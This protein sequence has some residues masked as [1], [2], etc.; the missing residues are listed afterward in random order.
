[1]SA[2]HSLLAQ[3]NALGSGMPLDTTLRASGFTLPA[4]PTT[5]TL[6]FQ[7]EPVSAD[8]T[9]NNAVVVASLDFTDA[10][11]NRYTLEFTL[12]QPGLGGPLSMR[13]EEQAGFLDGGSFYAS[14]SLPSNLVLSSWTPIS[15]TINRKTSM[16]TARVAFGGTTETSPDPVTL[17]MNVN[18]TQLQLTIGS[19]FEIEPS[20]GW[21]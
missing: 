14:H 11:G 13:L 5:F 6:A 1:M 19:S 17:T 16:V 10:P 3:D 2:P 8:T 9:T 18:P 12:F 7:F 4:P 21:K 15:L 20:A